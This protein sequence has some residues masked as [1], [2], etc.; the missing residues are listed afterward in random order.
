MI[1]APVSPTSIG[2]TLNQDILF[3]EVFNVTGITSF[4]SGDI[5]K[6][7]DEYLITE[8]VGV[9]GSTRISVRRAQLGSA[10][11]LHTTGA[12]ITKIMATTSLTI[13][14]LALVW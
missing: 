13:S 1:Q 3:Q 2:S 7:D 12:T 4:A 9:A 8:S 10:I 6:I 11:G 5:I 14:T